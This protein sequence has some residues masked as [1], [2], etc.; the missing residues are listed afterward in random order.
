MAISYSTRRLWAPRELL[1]SS[2]LA[3]AVTGKINRMR[4]WDRRV[5]V[6]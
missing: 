1:A 2:V 3:T 6:L 4:L 5:K